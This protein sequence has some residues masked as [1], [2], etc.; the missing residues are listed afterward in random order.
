M[1]EIG[2]ERSGLSTLCIKGGHMSCA[3][4]VWLTALKSA[5]TKTPEYFINLADVAALCC[6]FVFVSGYILLPALAGSPVNCDAAAAVF[7]VSDD[8]PVVAVDCQNLHYTQ[9][10]L[11]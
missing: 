1:N 3:T 9:F 10:S 4:L 8:T 2:S 5:P 7:F 11:A 6:L